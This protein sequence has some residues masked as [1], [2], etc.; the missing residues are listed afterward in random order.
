MRVLFPLLLLAVNLLAS[1]INIGTVTITIPQHKEL[2]A[3]ELKSKQFSL[4][5]STTPNT[6]RLLYCIGL[7]KELEKANKGEVV[8]LSRYMLIQTLRQTEHTAISPSQFKELSNTM[9]MEINA[10]MEKIDFNEFGN[11]IESNLEQQQG[12]NSKIEFGK[13]KLVDVPE[14]KD[15]QV[16]FTMIMKLKLN[17]AERTLVC[18]ASSFIVRSKLVYLYTYSIYKDSKDIEWVNETN[19]TFV[20]KLREVN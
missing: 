17:D 18:C 1:V 20:K 7:P 13:P 6:N 16:V 2:I 14:Y 15:N 8:D 4:L 3:L 10:G 11:A 5:E 12:I 9:I 19:N